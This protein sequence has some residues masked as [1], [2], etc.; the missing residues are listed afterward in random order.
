MYLGEVCVH[1]FDIF[2]LTS[3][4]FLNIN[5][6]VNKILSMDEFLHCTR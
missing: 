3:A 6:L 4:Q 5:M 1:K 2:Q